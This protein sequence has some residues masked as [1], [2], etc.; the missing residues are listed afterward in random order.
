MV[1]IV[2][3]LAL[4]ASASLGVALGW[5]EPYWV[6]EPI[7]ILT[8]YIIMGKRERIREKAIATTLGVI[9]AVPVAL[10]SLPTWAISVIATTAFVVALTQLKR[11]WLYY[12]LY[13]FAVGSRPLDARQRRYRGGTSWYRD[14]R[15]D[16]HPRG[17]PGGHPG[18]WGL[19]IEALPPTRS[20]R[21][22]C[23]L[24]LPGRAPVEYP[25]PPA[26]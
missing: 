8:L 21:L 22:D 1:A 16:R 7:L 10:I 17:R 13:T 15:R 26:W 20:R 14:S 6:P 3:G 5:T 2:F 25:S 12:S 18:P 19:A 23:P 11:Y 4:G 24:V 9:A